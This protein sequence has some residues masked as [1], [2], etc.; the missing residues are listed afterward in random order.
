MLSGSVHFRKRLLRT[1]GR[2]SC[3]V[4][5][6]EFCCDDCLWDDFVLLL[7]AGLFLRVC[8]LKTGLHMC[9]CVIFSVS[10]VI[11][12][13]SECVELNKWLYICVVNRVSLHACTSFAASCLS[14]AASFCSFYA[15]KISCAVAQFC[16]VCDADFCRPVCES[17]G[18]GLPQSSCL[19]CEDDRWQLNLAM[20]PSTCFYFFALASSW[21]WFCLQCLLGNIGWNLSDM[22][23]DIWGPIYTVSYDDLT[24]MPKLRSTYGGCVIYETSYNY[25]KVNLGYN[26]TSCLTIISDQTKTENLWLLLLLFLYKSSLG[27]LSICEV[28]IVSW[29]YE[30]CD[31][32]YNIL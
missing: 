20:F 18:S 9:V 17:C 28:T 32:L 31:K 10:H 11:T 1:S 24:I 5:V 3:H 19:K 12:V 6:V 16:C 29:F 23:V 27:Y 22:S 30:F 7:E 8:W 21:S 26:S 14:R 2:L 13:V 25:R 4:Q 15:L